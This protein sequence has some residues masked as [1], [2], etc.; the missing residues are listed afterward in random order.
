MSLFCLMFCLN[1]FKSP[2]DPLGSSLR[3]PSGMRA[4]DMDLFIINMH[5]LGYFRQPPAE[6]IGTQVPW[7]ELSVQD[8]VAV[9]SLASPDMESGFTLHISTVLNR[10]QKSSTPILKNTSAYE[11]QTQADFI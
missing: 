11:V 7:C 1:H 10:R 5:L 6:H 3:P 2:W 9:S 4:A 8:G